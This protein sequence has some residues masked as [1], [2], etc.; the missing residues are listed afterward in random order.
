MNVPTIAYSTSMKHQKEYLHPAVEMTYGRQQRA[1]LDEV[2]AQGKELTL[3]GDGRCDS[4]GHSAKYGSY[5]LLDLEMNKI[6]DSQ[7]LQV[8]E[9]I[10]TLKVRKGPQ[11]PF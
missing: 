10:S 6:L 9:F 7:L 4:P 1:L 11:A 2:K 3:G 5:T 8:C